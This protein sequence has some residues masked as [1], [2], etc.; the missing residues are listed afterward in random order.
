M[1]NIAGTYRLVVQR[2][3]SVGFT[4]VSWLLVRTGSLPLVVLRRGSVIGN[5]DTPQ[6]LANLA[7]CLVKLA[8]PMAGLLGMLVGNIL[9]E[10]ESAHRPTDGSQCWMYVAQSNY[11]DQKA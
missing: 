5:T 11:W 10:F 2:D 1:R 9:V 4:M 8:Q 6:T 3:R 7:A